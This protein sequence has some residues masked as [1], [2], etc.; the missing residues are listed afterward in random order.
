[1]SLELIDRLLD[2]WKNPEYTGFNDITLHKFEF[3][4]T[5]IDVRK[6]SKLIFDVENSKYTQPSINK[7]ESYGN[8]ELL[9]YYE[10]MNIRPSYINKNIKRNFHK[11]MYTTFY[12]WP[13]LLAKFMNPSSEYILELGFTGGFTTLYMLENT[14]SYVITIDKM[15]FDYHYFGKNFV[16]A[17][18]PNRH[19][20]LVGAPGQLTTHFDEHYKNIKFGL[21]YINKSKHFDHIYNYLVSYRKYAHEDT[22]IFLK[23]TTPHAAWGIG[24]YMAMTKAVSEGLVILID[25]FLLDDNYYVS[26]SLLKYNF[27]KDYVQKIPLK[28]YIQME[29][30]VGLSEFL[31]F[32]KLNHDNNLGRVDKEFVIKYRNK[33]RKFNIEF[34][35]EIKTYLEDKYKIILDE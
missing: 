15:N 26:A 34:D 22:I 5:D 29:Y 20:L 4:T 33:F 17:K 35:E 9:K 25:N 23:G 32:I 6:S 12:G 3:P 1:M 13:K 2:N 28:K 8:N 24:A 16:D 7:I 14:T 21:I 30:K 18:Y 27:D 31:S 10:D 11:M 19:T